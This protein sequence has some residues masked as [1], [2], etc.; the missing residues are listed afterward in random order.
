MA[1]ITIR[2]WNGCTVRQ[3]ISVSETGSTTLGAVG[4]AHSSTEVDIELDPWAGLIVDKRAEF[5][6]PVRIVEALETG[7]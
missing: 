4:G 2:I 6:V 1:D 3:V 5:P 7:I